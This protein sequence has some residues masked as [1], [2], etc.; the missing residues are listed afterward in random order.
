MHTLGSTA[1][2]S[3]LLSLTNYCMT[4]SLFLRVFCT[5]AENRVVLLWD[6]SIVS[7]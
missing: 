4:S 7:I 1:A 6:G 3:S 5:G 2:D